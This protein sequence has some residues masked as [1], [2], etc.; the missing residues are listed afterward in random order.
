VQEYKKAFEIAIDTNFYTS[1]KEPE[2]SFVTSNLTIDT[3]VSEYI[4]IRNELPQSNTNLQ[5]TNEE[6]IES[7]EMHK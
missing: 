5:S 4:E 2:Y 3:I 7:K 6:E 1:V